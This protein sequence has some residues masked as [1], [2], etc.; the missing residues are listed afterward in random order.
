MKDGYLIEYRE[1]SL[2]LVEKR[3]NERK[4]ALISIALFADMLSC[5]KYMVYNAFLVDMEEYKRN[6]TETPVDTITAV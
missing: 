5:S 6:N 4:K 1:R 2:Y 3:S